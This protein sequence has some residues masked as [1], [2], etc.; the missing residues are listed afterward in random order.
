MRVLLLCFAV[1]MTACAGGVSSVRQTLGNLAVLDAAAYKAL[2]VADA[3]KHAAIDVSIPMNPLKAE[4]DLHAW[5]AARASVRRVLDG[6]QDA[7]EVAA[8]L[9][10]D[11]D[12]GLKASPDVMAWIA[13]LVSLAPKI[14]TTLLDVGVKL[15]PSV[16]SFLGGAK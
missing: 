5:Q 10:D 2:G 9:C 1:A 15:P 14:I 16:T 12:N 3:A 4:A 13:E 8:Q 7:I 11:I 6:T